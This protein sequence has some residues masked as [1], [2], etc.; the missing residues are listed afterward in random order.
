VAGNGQGGRVPGLRRAQRVHL[1]VRQRG[2][3]NNP[4]TPPPTP[5]LLDHGNASLRR[6]VQCGHGYGATAWG[7]APGFPLRL[8]QRADWTGVNGFTSQADVLIRARQAADLVGRH[9]DGPAPSGSPPTPGSRVEI[10]NRAHPTTTGAARRLPP[11]TGRTAPPRWPA[12][13]VRRSTTPNPRAD[14][15]WGPPI[16]WRWNETG[17][18]PHVTQPSPGDIFVIAGNPKAG[19][20]P[21]DLPSGSAHV[22]V[23]NMF[24]QPR[25]TA[26][27]FVRAGCGSRP[28]AALIEQAATS[29]DSGQTTRSLGRRTW[30]FRRDRAASSWAPPPA[31]ITGRY[32]GRPDRRTMFHQMSSSPG[33]IGRAPQTRRRRP[34]A[35]SYT[36]HDIAREPS[37][38]SRSSRAGG[39][40]ATTVGQFAA[41]S[42]PA[43]SSCAAAMR[44]SWGPEVASSC[45]GAARR[46]PRAGNAWRY[47]PPATRPRSREQLSK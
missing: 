4:R 31:E 12:R 36:Q 25:R 34:T 27:R 28:T 42:G 1:Q 33:E 6:Q 30:A 37:E 43:R 35:S 15:Q 14:N 2:Q 46:A 3:P 22:T 8:R 13:P 29:T 19:D 40:D 32:P 45:G 23:D 18:D 41:A 17:G 39:S 21:H 7:R 10:Y 5:N 38:G 26:V 16:L 11:R 24:N 47:R 9:H 44:E 20:G